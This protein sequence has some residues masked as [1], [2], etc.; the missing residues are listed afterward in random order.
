MTQSYNQISGTYDF[1]SVVRALQAQI[2]SQG[3]V[4][5][6]YPYNFEGITKAIQDLTFAETSNP[7]A[8]IGPSPSQGNVIIDDNG[9]PQFN[10][11]TTPLDGDLWFDTRQGRLFIAY[12]SEW[13]QTNGGDGFPVVTTTDVPPAATNLVVGQMWY[14]RTNGVLYIFAGQYLETDG[15]TTTTPTATTVPVWSQ[16]VDTSDVQTSMTLPLGDDTTLAALL[17]LFNTTEFL[18]RVNVASILNQYQ[19]NDLVAESVILLDQELEKRSISMSINAPNSSD[20]TQN[21]PGD[22]WFDTEDIELSIWYVAP[23]TNYGQWVPTFNAS[24]VDDN[25]NT[26]KTGLSTETSARKAADTTLQTNIDS[27]SS[28]VNTHR[29]EHNNSIDSLQA[30]INAI[31]SVDLS[32]YITSAQEQTDIRNLQ[33]QVDTARADIILM[34]KGFVTQGALT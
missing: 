24:T 16:L 32:P 26:L 7:G 33:N 8:D 27:L 9:D 30:Q 2:A 15:T 31:P 13:Y 14:D 6:E 21:R 12:Q 10:Y 18:P 5:K 29:S 4:V 34:Y 22:L 25:L 19:V 23:G 11:A 17:P 28:T 3:G 1:G 20:P